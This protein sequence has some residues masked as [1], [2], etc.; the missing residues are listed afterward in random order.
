MHPDIYK[1]DQGQRLVEDS[2]RQLLARW[3]TPNRQFHV[4]TRFGRTHVISCGAP[5]HLP[6]LI[7]FHGSASN[8]A[9]WLSDMTI[10]AGSRELYAIDMIGEPGLSAPVRPA[11]DSDQHFIW[12]NDALEALHIHKF[13]AVGVSLG[14][15]LLLDY[16]TRAPERV[17]R[18]CVLSPGG[19]G[20]QRTSFLFKVLPLL[21]LGDW[22]VKKALQIAMGGNGTGEAHWVYMDFMALV[23]K[24]FKP[25]MQQLPIFGD[26]ALSRLTMPILAVLGGKDAI[27]DSS[28]TRRRLSRTLPKAQIIYLPDVGH[29]IFGER[30]AISRFL[31]SGAAV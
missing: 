8:A 13:A 9:M 20:R 27:L 5:S 16:A 6:P 22:G 23:Q 24:S 18:L 7:L 12:L 31:G 19:I 1:S 21:I 11:L 10:W 14:G 15:W 2:Y 3:R 29:G 28:D 25:R 4:Q 26:L 30:A 17:E